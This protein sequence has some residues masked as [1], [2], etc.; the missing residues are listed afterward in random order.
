MRHYN[1]NLAIYP[2]LRYFLKLGLCNKEIRVKIYNI[3]TVFFIFMSLRSF[4][5]NSLFIGFA[6]SLVWWDMGIGVVG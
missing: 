4:T 3:C 5:I 6:Y 1:C 2:S